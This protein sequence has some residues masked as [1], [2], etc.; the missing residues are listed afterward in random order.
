MKKT[1]KGVN[2]SLEQ[3]YRLLLLLVDL[4]V[5]EGELLILKNVTVGTTALSRARADTS[6]DLSRG[7]L[8]NDLLLLDNGLLSLL[9][10]GNHGLA[11]ALHL[12]QVIEL[13]R[14]LADLAG[15]VLLEPGLEGGSIDLDN[16][17]LHDGVGTHELVV[18]GVVH[19]VQDLSLGGESYK[20]HRNSYTYP[21]QARRSFRYPDGWHGA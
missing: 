15:V 21:H 1:N 10:L 2:V 17:S 7:E 16:A 14:A 13:Q 6:H 19:N 11:L 20:S 9:E 18:G 8:V 12:G 5:V 3:L 4:L